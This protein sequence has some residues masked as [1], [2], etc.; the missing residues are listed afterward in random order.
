VTTLFGFI[1]SEYMTAGEYKQA[2]IIYKEQIEE[3]KK[4]LEYYKNS[5]SRVNSEP[6]L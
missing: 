2:N 1:T 3:F 5:S 4:E 6:Q